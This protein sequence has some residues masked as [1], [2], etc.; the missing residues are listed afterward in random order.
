[1]SLILY[2]T[3][4]KEDYSK[5]VIELLKNKKQNKICYITFNKTYNYLLE[6]FEKN[7]FKK[8]NLFII[9]CVSG[10]VKEPSRVKNCD[11][12]SEPYDLK[13]I[14]FSVKKFL[15]QGCNII[16]FDSLSGLMV[17]GAI[18]PAGLEIL[19]RFVQS[20]IP[21]LNERKGDAIFLCKKGDKE[22]LLILETLSIFNKIKEI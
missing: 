1:M 10:L 9:D 17:Y 18:V 16:V 6:L 5:E 11:F 15:E 22:K 7:G 3:G 8:E 21:E 19:K 12:I 20:F 13:R 4:D 14:E 2:Y